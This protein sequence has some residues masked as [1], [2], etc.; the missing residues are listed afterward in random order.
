MAK[1][2]TNG[3]EH[4]TQLEQRLVLLRWLCYQLGYKDNREALA[5]TKSIAEGFGADGRSYLYHHLLARG[6]IKIDSTDL[7][8][9]DE[10]K[11]KI[12]STDLARYDENI[13][14][15]LARLNRRRTTPITLRYFQHLA[16]L[17]TEIFLDRLFTDRQRLLC[18]LN[19]FVAERNKSLI[20]KKQQK[21]NK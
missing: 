20:E 18:D 8:R 15:H 2:T 9:Y 3:K 11:V 14:M 5:D 13:R 17:Y 4:Y 12:D 1:A 6:S 10:N 16:A 21:N 19:S 7:A